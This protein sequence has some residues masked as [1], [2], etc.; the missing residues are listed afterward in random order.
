MT[1]EPPGISRFPYV[2]IR[3]MAG[4]Y[5]LREVVFVPDSPGGDEVA[6]QGGPITVAHPLPFVDGTLTDEARHAVVEKVRRVSTASRFRLCVVLGPTE[7]VF[8]EPDGTTRESARA[9][10]G[11]VRLDAITNFTEG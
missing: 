6:S 4:V 7:V 5:G 10:S 8:V 2:V 9:P 3:W 11:G 1:V